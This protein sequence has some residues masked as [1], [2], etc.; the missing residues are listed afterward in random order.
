MRSNASRDPL[1]PLSVILP[2]MMSGIAGLC[3]VSI[4]LVHAASFSTNAALAPTFLIILSALGL[5]LCIAALLLRNGM[6]ARLRGE[7]SSLGAPASSEPV[8]TPGASATG[9]VPAR[10]LD[11]RPNSSDPF[12]TPS[13]AA[14]YQQARIAANFVTLTL[15]SGSLAEGFGLFGAVI[16][17][18]TG[19]S[20][21][22]VAPAIALFLI[23]RLLPIRDRLARFTEL[24]ERSVA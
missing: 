16:Y 10:E 14:E 20:Y 2:A 24:V 12:R 9:P 13:A 21:A 8:Q 11:A 22:L 5:S 15:I 3:V 1:R 23:A 7:I 6:I 18:I 17:L 4:Y 19:D